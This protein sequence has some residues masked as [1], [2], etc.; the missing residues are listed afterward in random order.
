MRTE[1][2]P[3]MTEGGVRFRVLGPSRCPCCPDRPRCNGA[4]NM[5]WLLVESDWGAKVAHPKSYVEQFCRP[6]LMLV[7]GE[8]A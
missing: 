2:F 3:M 5:E 1:D 8:Q 4:P 7:A 6:A